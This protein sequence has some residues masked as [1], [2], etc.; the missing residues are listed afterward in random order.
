MFQVPTEIRHRNKEVKQFFLVYGGTCL[1]S[2]SEY[3]C[4]INFNYCAAIIQI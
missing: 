3:C 2:P 1:F 4:Y